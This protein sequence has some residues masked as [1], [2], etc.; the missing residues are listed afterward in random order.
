M[1][2]SVVVQNL[3]KSYGANA[4]LKGITFSVASGE[5][6][7]LLGTNGAGKTTTL[8]CL[9]GIRKYDGGDIHLKGKIGVQLQSSSLPQNIKAFEAVSL[10]A[11]WNKA[12]VDTKYIQRLGIMEFKNKQYKELSTGQKRRLHLGLAILGDPDIIFLDEPTAGLDVEG[13]V[14]LHEE[15]RQM[16]AKGKTILM[17]SH[18]MAEVE[19]L[20]DKIAILKDG[21]IVFSGTAAE[22]TS[23]IGTS[24]II[25]IQTALGED[26][27]L[28]ENIAEALFRQLEIYRLKNI[29]ILDIKIERASLEQRFIE[30]AR[31]GV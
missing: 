31:E 13:R 10:F 22:L 14:A 7:A 5:I 19:E 27:V 12:E 21:N 18:D 26:T 17:A 16:K 29:P 1:N 8:E 25:H 24:C 2:K 11:K 20:C 3:T 15:I 23:R 4:V 30:I 28:T 9:E 6:F